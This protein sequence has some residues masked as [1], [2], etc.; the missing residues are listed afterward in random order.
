M[1]GEGHGFT[2]KDSSATISS[3]CIHQMAESNYESNRIPILYISIASV[4]LLTIGCN[5]PLCGTKTK[6]DGYMFPY[7]GENLR[8]VIAADKIVIPSDNLPSKGFD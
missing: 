2:A 6:I 7:L 8:I 3:D 4:Y 1:F 5:L